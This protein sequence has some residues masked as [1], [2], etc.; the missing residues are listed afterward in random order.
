MNE[1]PVVRTTVNFIR[2]SS[3]NL[4]LALQ[5]VEAMP[6][7]KE[8]LIEEFLASVESAISTDQWQWHTDP[9]LFKKD[10]CLA[11]R[12]ADW[13]ADEDPEDR[14]GI[15]LATDKAH[16][17]R[18]YVG[19]YI[20]EVTRERIRVNE[21]QILPRLTGAW[22]ELPRGNGWA[23]PLKY[24]LEHLAKEKGFATYRY[25]N[26]PVDDWGS[27]Q[28]LLDSLDDDRKK[29]MVAQ[30]IRQMEFLKCGASALVEAIR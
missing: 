15:A 22:Q 17:G 3:K 11:L 5:I 20:S 27:P 23:T 29:E 26:E 12:N 2:S 7:L 19:V 8:D 28:F 1:D 16:W 14:T 21:R 13:L 9:D 24:S 30:I 25:L 10:V 18:V 4:N 6:R